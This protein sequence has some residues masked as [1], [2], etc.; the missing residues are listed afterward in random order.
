[1]TRLTLPSRPPTL[2]EQVQEILGQIEVRLANLSGSGS[3]AMEII[4]L[5]D[6]VAGQLEE[7]ETAGADVRAE[8]G[9][10]TSVWQGLKRRAR[11]FLREVGP[12]LRIERER[13]EMDSLA[14]WWWI[15]RVYA[16]KRRRV[17]KKRL[18]TTL[19]ALLTAAAV[20]LVYQQFLAP[21]PEVRQAL[22][23]VASGEM[24]L[25]DGDLEGALVA[26]EAAADLTP[27][28]P[29]AL[30]RVGAMRQK[31]GDEEGAQA[32]YEAV[33]ELGISE[34][35]FLVQ[36]GG[37]FLQMR[38]L[39]A[40]RADAEMIIELDA[41]WGYGFYLRASVEM[42]EGETQAALDDY[43]TAAEMAHAAGDAQL[44]ALAR[45]QMALLL[46]SAPLLEEE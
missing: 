45:M 24:R 32:A 31:L 27:N 21:P 9:Y 46:Q 6:Q 39:E 14:P 16:Q 2:L 38:E 1:M 17:L 3:D 13:Q 11:R 29:E 35:E 18:L 34:R 8:R 7:L 28:D 12:A 10:L 19:L 20:W 37:L 44:E 23:Y 43:S 26:F 36:R 5:L 33:R 30:I 42:E 40:A 41:E 25:D 15:D 4:S 22:D